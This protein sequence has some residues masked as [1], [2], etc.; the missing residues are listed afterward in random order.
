[1]QRASTQKYLRLGRFNPRLQLWATKWLDKSG[2][3]LF[4][5]FTG[6]FK[7]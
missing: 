1:M 7:V 4:E 2:V 5:N 3:K 6:K